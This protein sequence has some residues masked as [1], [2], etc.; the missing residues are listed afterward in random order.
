[1]ETKWAQTRATPKGC[2]RVRTWANPVASGSR[3]KDVDY[4]LGSFSR[5]S[6]FALANPQADSIVDTT[7]GSYWREI[8]RNGTEHLTSAKGEN[9]SGVTIVHVHLHAQDDIATRV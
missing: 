9:R 7:V 8:E 4:F 2:R 6:Y 5:F 1:M 3:L